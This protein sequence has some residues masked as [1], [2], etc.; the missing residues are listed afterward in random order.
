[1]MVLYGDQG[2][3]EWN[4]HILRCAVSGLVVLPLGGRVIPGGRLP[5]GL[6]QLHGGRRRGRFR[7]PR[8]ADP[9]R[10]RG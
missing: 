2:H 10:D 4:S 1:M 3:G 9:D 8:R 7:S 6:P 5:A